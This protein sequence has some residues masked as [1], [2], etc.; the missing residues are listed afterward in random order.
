MLTCE[1][2][3]SIIVIIFRRCLALLDHLDTDGQEISDA[4]F[5][6]SPTYNQSCGTY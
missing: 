3:P 6:L 4:A 5:I 2:I 1:V